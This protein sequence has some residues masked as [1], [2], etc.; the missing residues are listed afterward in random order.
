LPQDW[1][2]A[3]APKLIVL[4]N[5][6]TPAHIANPALLQ[7]LRGIG[8]E[9]ISTQNGAVTISVRENQWRVRTMREQGDWEVES[10]SNP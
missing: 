1:V 8:A 7:R 5:S 3:I 6:D 9:I 4:G 2:K 10:V